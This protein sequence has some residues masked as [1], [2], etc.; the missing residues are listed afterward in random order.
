MNR[1][2]REPLLHF[3]LIGIALFVGYERL[4]SPDLT[5]K[6]IVV[7]DA[8]VQQM[9]REHEAR[10]TRKPNEQELA[11]LIESY[12]RDEILYREGL[13]LGLDRDDTLIKRRVRQK[14]EVIAEEEGAQRTP[15]DADLITYMSDNAARFLLPGR[16][17]F[18]QVF[19]GD[20]QA[21]AVAERAITAARV[22][23]ARGSEPSRLGQ[24]SL[25]PG[26]VE[27]GAQDMVARD[28]GAAFARQ[29]ETAPLGQWSGLVQSSF[30]AHLVRVSA[31]TPASLPE[32]DAVR[33]IVAREWESERRASARSDHYR[34]LRGNYAVVIEAKNLPSLAA[35]R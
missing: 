7:N 11:G 24:T 8:M 21:P 32:L 29:V 1:L 22:A 14:F 27:N 5:G 20:V 15:S 31:R 10:W 6:R 4:A 18:E 9:A 34:K 33:L 35:Q 25:L 2:L 16:V 23:L 26:R 30:G 17:S 19:F 3:L 28:F 12:V 13:A